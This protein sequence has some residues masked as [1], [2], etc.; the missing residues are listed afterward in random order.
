[1]L[2]LKFRKVEVT[3]GMSYQLVATVEYLNRWRTTTTLDLVGADMVVCFSHLIV[4][5]KITLN[6]TRTLTLALPLTLH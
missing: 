4:F 6:L 5:E 2:I 3:G 1:M